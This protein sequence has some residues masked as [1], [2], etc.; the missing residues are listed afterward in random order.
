M[1]NSQSRPVCS[2]ATTFQARLY[3]RARGAAG[4]RA[5]ASWLR[6]SST[7]PRPSLERRNTSVNSSETMRGI[8]PDR[9]DRSAQYIS[10]T[11]T[12]AV[13]VATSGSSS[14]GPTPWRSSETT[15][16]S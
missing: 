4:S 1:T 15:V 2:H 10:K 7:V 14:P 11:S 8:E 12:C 9:R 6:I 3:A 13:V 16:V 5:R